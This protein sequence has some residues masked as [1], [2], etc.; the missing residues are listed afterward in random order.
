MVVVAE[1]DMSENIHSDGYNK[2]ELNNAYLVRF[3][4]AAVLRSFHELPDVEKPFRFAAILKKEKSSLFF[5][6]FFF[7]DR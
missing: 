2:M 3:V 5:F 7:F 1:V 4:V 6:L